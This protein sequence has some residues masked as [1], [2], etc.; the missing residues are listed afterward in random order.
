MWHSKKLTISIVLAFVLLFGVIGGVALA[1]E[2]DDS[3]PSRIGF[4]DRLADKLGITTQELKDK[5]AEVQAELPE[6]ELRGWLVRRGPIN[7]LKNVEEILGI[8]IDEDALKEALI[9]ARD[10]IKAGEDRQEVMAEVFER[11]GIDIEELK[12]K[13]E[14]FRESHQQMLREKSDARFFGPGFGFKDR[15]AFHG[16][17]GPCAPE[18]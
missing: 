14:E 9:E 2:S 16:T 13:C 3:Q 17:S 1:Q 10:R 12:T 15:G 6:R 8:D 11:F 5:I 7:C 18:E 4:L